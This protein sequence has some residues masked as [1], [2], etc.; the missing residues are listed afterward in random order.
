MVSWF[1]RM[2]EKSARAGLRPGDYIRAI[3]GQSTRDTSVYEGMRL[4]SGKPGRPF[5]RTADLMKAIQYF[6]R[7]LTEQPNELE[8]RWL[9]NIAHMY[10]GTYP[11]GV[12]RAPP[13]SR[14]EAPRHRARPRCCRAARRT[15]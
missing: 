9:L 7:Y 4:L 11:G 14:R 8:V 12:P 1:W 15:R 2:D 6:S 10:A 3:D 13:A 5:A